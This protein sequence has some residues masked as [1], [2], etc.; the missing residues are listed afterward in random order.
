MVNRRVHDPPKGVARIQHLGDLGLFKEKTEVRIFY[1]TSFTFAMLAVT[2]IGF[3]QHP[4]GPSTFAGWISVS[5]SDLKCI[6]DQIDVYIIVSPKRVKRKITGQKNVPSWSTILF[7]SRY[8]H[9]GDSNNFP[10]A[11]ISVHLLSEI[12]KNINRNIQNYQILSSASGQL[13][14]SELLPG[15]A[16]HS[17]CLPC[18]SQR[19]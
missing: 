2:F 13:N 11:G 8:L 7:L 18:G 6:N 10:R 16:C 3:L 19:R 12:A 9:C 17:F 1:T 5:T 14:R 15:I 4:V